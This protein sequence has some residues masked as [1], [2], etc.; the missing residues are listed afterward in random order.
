[1]H[2]KENIKRNATVNEKHLRL[3]VKYI[4]FI[5]LQCL[6]DHCTRLMNDYAILFSVLFCET[7]KLIQCETYP[8]T[9]YPFL[10]YS[11]RVFSKLLRETLDLPKIMQQQCQKHKMLTNL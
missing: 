2:H 1:M 10:K 7:A 6:C 4:Y 5:S 8:F 9:P 3:K 11:S